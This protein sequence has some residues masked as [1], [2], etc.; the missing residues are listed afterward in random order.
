MMMYVVDF[1]VTTVAII[2]SF[3]VGRYM[4]QQIGIAKMRALSWEMTK[5]SRHIMLKSMRRLQRETIGHD[6]ASW[7]EAA[8]VEKRYTHE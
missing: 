7:I 3:K 1:V 5:G 8:V 6:Y 2:G 4:E